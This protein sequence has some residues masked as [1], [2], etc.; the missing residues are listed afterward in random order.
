MKAI[1]QREYGSTDSLR[2]ED[3][4]R[5][6][7]KKDEVLIRVQAAAVNDYDW[8]LVRGKPYLYRL[9]FG[10]TEPR[11]RIPGMEVSGVVESLGPEAK[12]FCEKDEVFGDTSEFGFGCFAE[13]VAVSEK[14]L[15]KKPETKSFVEAA[16]I[17]HAA[18]L[19]FQGLQDLGKIANGQKLLINGAGG[20]VGSFGLQIAK[21]WNAE[22][23]GVD[24]GPKL[25]MMKQI[26]F[27]HVV[28]YRREDF[29]R[30]GKKY[31]LILDTKT[32]RS[33]WAYLRSLSPGGR[34]VTVGGS[35][36]RLLQ[37]FVLGPMLAGTADKKIRILALKPNK[38]IEHV[39][40]LFA[41]GKLK[42]TID[43]PYSLAEAPKAIR[44]F[45][46]GRHFGKVVLT[47]ED[48]AGR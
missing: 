15:T 48:T 5:P 39:V 41:S 47:L 43:G 16:S 3:V 38:G 44:R 33:P 45:G 9:M 22:V 17:P 37:A 46:Q 8:S 35:L 40:E 1:V 13:Y 11:N 7:P 27:D 28:D 19:A 23:T 4:E 10:L 21:L 6:S 30:S 34:Y 42:C 24:T 25:E 29:T 18:M 26:G 31:D 20:G 14:A 2:L 32:T 36:P 12:A